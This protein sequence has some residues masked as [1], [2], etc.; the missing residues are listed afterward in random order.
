LWGRTIG[1][2]SGDYSAE[3]FPLKNGDV[4][5]TGKFARSVRF[6][7]TDESKLT[8]TGRYGESFVACYSKELVFKW[9]YPIGE[10]AVSNVAEATIAS[11]TAG[12]LYISGGNSTL[13][14]IDKNGDVVYKKSLGIVPSCVAISKSQHLYISGSFS[15]AVDFNPGPDSLILTAKAPQEL[16]IVKYSSLLNS[17][18]VQKPLIGKSM[19]H[20][21][22]LIIKDRTVEISINLPFLSQVKIGLYDARGRLVNSFAKFSLSAG[23]HYLPVKFPESLSASPSLFIIKCSI[24]GSSVSAI[25]VL[26]P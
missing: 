22:S 16:Y 20:K 25:P 3:I 1:D 10:P 21:V 11:D 18:S 19:D 12:N 17:Q 9:A 13:C 2:T 7:L 5:I 4:V 23:A 24:N 26:L 6:G 15:G 14:I 8:T